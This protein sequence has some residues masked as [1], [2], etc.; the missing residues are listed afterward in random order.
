MNE[1][2]VRRL[3]DERIAVHN[4]DLSSHDLAV[5]RRHVDLIGSAVGRWTIVAADTFTGAV[6]PLKT[7][8]VGNLAWQFFSGLPLQRSGGAA[9][10]ID[11]ELRVG[12]VAAGTPDGQVEANLTPGNNQAN[13]YLRYHS[14]GNYMM[15]GRGADGF[16]GLYR[17]LDGVQSL[18]EPPLY[19]LPATGE[20]FR[21]RMVGDR[22]W[23]FRTAG[24]FDELLF[25]ATEASLRTAG[26]HGIRVIGTGTVDDFR[27]LAREAL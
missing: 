19:R 9:R 16:I 23:I 4:H 27:I 14:P 13:L 1:D 21:A 10:S 17:S 7:T 22:V 18:M 2:D 26:T 24:D 3:I 6:S 25:H 5:L 20:R 8:E 15:L 12:Y 11:G